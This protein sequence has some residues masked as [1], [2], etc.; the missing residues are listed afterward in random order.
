[1]QR[2]R[3]IYNDDDGDDDVV[4]SYYVLYL[5]CCS[6]L[7]LL[8]LSVLSINSLLYFA[9]QPR[10]MVGV[11]FFHHG[12]YCAHQIMLRVATG[13]ATVL[14]SRSQEDAIGGRRNEGGGHER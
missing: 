5:L 1:M 13:S 12:H 3:V 14:E 4:V 8:P 2:I 10:Q 7:L 9:L 11:E 6:I